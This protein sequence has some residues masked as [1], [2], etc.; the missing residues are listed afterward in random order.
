MRIE[1]DRPAWARRVAQQAAEMSA[2]AATISDDYVRGEL[3]EYV[4]HLERH[5]QDLARPR[6]LGIP[7][8]N[9]VC[10]AAA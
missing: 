3:L 6:P 10:G 8:D 2:V 7:W 9:Q 5:A 1:L 4:G